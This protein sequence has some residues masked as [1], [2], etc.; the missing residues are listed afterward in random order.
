MRQTDKQT[1]KKKPKK[2]IVQ[3]KNWKLQKSTTKKG[4]KRGFKLLLKDGAD[5]RR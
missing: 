3:S 2:T 4:C 1:N 5:L